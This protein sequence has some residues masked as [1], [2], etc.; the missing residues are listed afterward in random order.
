MCLAK[1][2]KRTRTRLLDWF[3]DRFLVVSPLQSQ[4][5]LRKY[6]HDLSG[7][8]LREFVALINP[9]NCLGNRCLG[10]LMRHHFD[11]SIVSGQN[12]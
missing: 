9:E 2:E 11:R 7:A 12:N 5:G 10:A 1:V 6:L 3:G 8:F 4:A